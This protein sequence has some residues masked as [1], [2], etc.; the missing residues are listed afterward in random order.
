M[1]VSTKEPAAKGTGSSAK[2]RGRR[3]PKGG[4]MSLAKFLCPQM[5]AKGERGAGK[6]QILGMVG[7]C[8]ARIWILNGT[9][10]RPPA[11]LPPLRAP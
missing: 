6:W 10:A 1:P 2:P 5:F 11:P 4:T 3:K 8:A 7:L 9:A